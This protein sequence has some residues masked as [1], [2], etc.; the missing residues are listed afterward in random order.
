MNLQTAKEVLNKTVLSVRIAGAA[1]LIYVV[2][3]DLKG[4]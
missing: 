3:R 4:K 1:G 2:V